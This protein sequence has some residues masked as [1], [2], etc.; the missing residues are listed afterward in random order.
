MA[1]RLREGDGTGP[2]THHVALAHAGAHSTYEL[3]FL[4]SQTT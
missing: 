2:V 1:P 3:F 4:H